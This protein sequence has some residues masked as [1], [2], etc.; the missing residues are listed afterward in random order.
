MLAKSTVWTGVLGISLGASAASAGT[1]T[2]E[3]EVPRLNVASYH[4]PYMAGWIED[5][6]GA[7]K[8]DLFVWYDVG[9]KNNEGNKWLK[10]LRAWW[11][12]SGRNLNMPVDGL[13]GAT[14]A[15]GR[16]TLKFDSN[17][18][19][20]K[21]LASGDYVLRVEASREHGGA[22]VVRAPFTWDAKKAV[23][24]STKGSVE[25]GAVRFTYKP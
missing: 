12:K 13:S 20:L 8:G 11:R 24:A 1:A 23:T 10:D 4:K 5:A 18:K 25:V 21:G 2:L 17:H 16:H 15:P 3:V 9:L 22:E 7:H 14:H 19:A 6:S